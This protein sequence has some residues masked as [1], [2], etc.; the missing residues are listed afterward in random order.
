MREDFNVPV[1]KNGDIID[2]TKIRA[3]IPTIEHILAQ[4]GQLILMSHFGRPKGGPEEKYSL[5]KVAKHLNSLI[6][7]EVIMAPDCIGPEVE[8]MVEN[9]KP[10][11]VLLLENVRFHPGEEENDPEF[12][13]K[14]ASV[15]DIFVNDAFG[16][17][18][19]AHSST[20]GLADYLPAYA[21]F[22]LEKEV[23]MLRKVIENPER[24]R[25]AIL[26]GAKIKDKLGLIEHLLNKMDS[27]LI[28]GGMA[29][30]FLLAQGKSIG[31]SIYEEKQIP[32]AQRLLQR[33][34]EMKVQL[35][36]PVDVVVA[37]EIAN[38]ARASIVE[39]D[40]IP[41]DQM[42]VDIGPKT[43]Q[44]F[45]GA[46]AKAKTVVWNGPL[47]VFE[48]DQFAEGTKQVALALAQSQAISVVGGGES[49]A[50]VRKVGVE[51]HIT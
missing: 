22:L 33:A 6:E 10:G 7:A 18:H 28:G 38:Y 37:G 20:A 27:I 51:K 41:D 9:M 11:Q 5:K 3:A 44:A 8:R 45:G 16:S 42:I 2:D 21:G 19:R 35:L 23:S 39:V 34:R 4:K 1:D 30:T 12:T 48:I 32:E 36:L 29:N 31:K 49:V 14:L 47:G 50:A 25:L 15:G 17:A 43:I 26:G 40:Q 13:R 24:P 46:I